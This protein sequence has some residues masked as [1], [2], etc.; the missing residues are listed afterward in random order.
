MEKT[1]FEQI[2]QALIKK[3]KGYTTKEV[4]EEFVVEE[5][6]EKLIKKKI[7]TKYIP[8]DLSAVK[9]VLENIKKP[10]TIADFSDIELEEEIQ[11]TAKL[12]HQMGEQ[13]S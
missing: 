9:V 1:N 7:T 11:K 3:A 6:D 8:P 10:K 2:N 5:N 13:Q 12:I 4:V